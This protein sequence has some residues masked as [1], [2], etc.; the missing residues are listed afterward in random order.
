MVDIVPVIPSERSL[1]G[2]LDSKKIATSVSSLLPRNDNFISSFKFIPTN[3]RKFLTITIDLKAD[4]P[5]PT[6]TIIDAT[7]KF[8]IT[9]KIVKVIINIPQGC[10]KEIQMDKVKKALLSANFIAG[11]SKNVER[12]ERIKFDG[13]QE[14]ESLIPIEALKKY[15]ELKK[16]SAEKQKQLEQY[17]SQIL[18]SQVS[19][20]D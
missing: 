6:Q 10:D 5:N 9:D 3:A 12:I 1:R 17:A 13:S 15:F 2:N 8:D 16:Y 20:T 11:I 18:E 19:H 14:V 7:S 4:D